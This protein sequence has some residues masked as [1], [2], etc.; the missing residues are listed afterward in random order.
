MFSRLRLFLILAALCLTFFSV[1]VLHP[2]QVLYSDH[3]DLLAMH[4]PMKRFLVRSWQETG[5][6]PLW[7]PYSFAGTP[8]IQD[9]QVAAFYPLHWP[10]YLLPEERIGA[11]MSWLVLL[12]V[13]IAG[14]CM[15]A[16]ARGQGLGWTAALVA[17]IGYMFAGKW[18]LHVLA[19]GHYIIIPLAWLPLV[20][21]WLEQAVQRRS[22]LRA[23]LAAFVF[24]G[25]VLGTHPQMTL[26]A[27]VFI[28]LWT[29]GCWW[30]EDSNNA[31]AR[32]QALRACSKS[33]SQS[34]SP[35]YSGERGW[36]E[37]AQD[38]QVNP[39]HPRLL[40]PE[41]GGEGRLMEPSPSPADRS[42]PHFI[43]RWLILGAWTALLAAALSAV[44]L[45][46]A[47]E[48][49]PESSRAAG[50]SNHDILA[51]AG[52]TL[53]GLVGP[54]WTEG[55]E[56][57]AGLGILW[58]ASAVMAL[59]LG[60]GRVRYQA[61]LC[62]FLLFFS[63]GGAVFLQWL[64]G[65]RLFQLPGRMLMFLAFPIALLTGKTTQFLLDRQHLP[66]P[67][68]QMCPR[69][70]VRVLA[71]C[72]LL[73]ICA[74]GVSYLAWSRSPD[75]GGSFIAWLRQLPIRLQA[76]W[77]VLL[78]TAPSA[79]WLLG[80]RCRLQ[81]RVWACAWV[82]ILLAD[83]WGLTL[84]H[85]AVRSEGDL[86]R[87]SP[88][89]RYLAF[90]R[91]QQ[92]DERWRV[93]ERG[94]PGEP[95]SAPLGVALPMFG[96]AQLEP[97]LGY[98]SF[99]VRRTKEYLQFILD[100]D[101]AVRPRDGGF[102]YPIVEAFPIK[103]KGLLDLLGVRFVLQP[104]SDRPYFDA[105]GEPR[106]NGEWQPGL[107]D[108]HPEAYSFLAGGVQKLPPYRIFENR[109]TF[110][111]A[112]IVPEAAPLEEQTRVLEQMK[113]TNFRRTVLLEGYRAPGTAQPAS[114]SE[115]VGEAVISEYLPNRVRVKTHSA[116]PG[117]LVLTDV[118][119]PG[120]TCNVDG[121]PA[122]VYRAD[123]L[124]RSIPVPAGD[125]EVNF[126]FAP[127]SYGLGKG[128]SMFAA[129][130]FSLLLIAAGFHALA[131]RSSRPANGSSNPQFQPTPRVRATADVGS[132]PEN[133]WH[134]AESSGEP[135]RSR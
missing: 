53:L 108:P 12:H 88:A 27:G 81:H 15:A 5:E 135:G 49:A 50:V 45:L 109:S 18:L 96:T 93:L 77:L 79:L 113:T 130:I 133:P 37:G 8:F 40:F 105:P 117:F 44:Q 82:G 23:T 99:D 111:R 19:G 32:R 126:A 80:D 17:A 20:L 29:F 87:P 4:L 26:Y 28:A 66:A 115:P 76:Y 52:P 46:P 85:V 58:I 39:P 110:P 25:I 33:C 100:G 97:V 10:L 120:W 60:S 14:C 36:G 104:D 59:Y 129:G 62:L 41:Y 54:G 95:S 21:L 112:F 69:V 78:F 13:L 65:F 103:N 6:I 31:S 11:V 73:S 51:S 30:K 101:Q 122:E 131:S 116:Q 94:L 24:A 63:L 106:V 102:G 127:R 74:A 70:L 71:I 92:P 91:A 7:S 42:S 119:F 16:Y 1:L 124:F 83:A 68:A 61:S 56:D 125:H 47:L 67:A 134:R 3:S 89:V 57:R 90:S 64:P 48:A 75:S 38:S 98:N 128:I 114:T 121:R 43:L 86:Y 2:G 123:F 35:P 9:V 72:L 118:W 132:P 84:P 107:E 55:W 34:P 22:F